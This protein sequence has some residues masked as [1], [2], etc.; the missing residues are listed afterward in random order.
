MKTFFWI[1]YRNNGR[2]LVK[3]GIN[4]KTVVRKTLIIQKTRCKWIQNKR[5]I[6]TQ[7]TVNS[8][9][10]K[11][12]FTINTTWQTTCKNCWKTLRISCSGA[13]HPS[14]WTIQ[15]NYSMFYSETENNVPQSSIQSKSLSYQCKRALKFPAICRP[16][17]NLTV[18]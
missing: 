7:K 9:G 1:T 12:L 2:W 4:W 5:K 8:S 14:K 3:T 16:P 13:I 6:F 10:I 11:L 15:K 18:D 17:T